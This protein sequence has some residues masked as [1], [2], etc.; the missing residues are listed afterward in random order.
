MSGATIITVCV[1]G[2]LVVAIEG[3]PKGVVVDVHDYD[4]DD[5]WDIDELE[6][7][8]AGEQYRASRWRGDESA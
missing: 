4:V 3:I 1:E 5:A 7:N 6:T 2:G 8:E